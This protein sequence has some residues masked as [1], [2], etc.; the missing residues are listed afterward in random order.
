MSSARGPNRAAEGAGA[1]R[2]KAC[3]PD[4]RIL[5]RSGVRGVAFVE[6]VVAGTTFGSGGGSGFRGGVRQR[7]RGLSH[8]RLRRCPGVA[9]GSSSGCERR[10]CVLVGARTAFGDGRG[11]DVACA[12]DR[13]PLRAAVRGGGPNVRA[14]ALLRVAER[15]VGSVGRQRGFNPMATA[16]RRGRGVARRMKRALPSFGRAL[17]ELWPSRLEWA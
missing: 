3:W 6:R 5:L 1:D 12:E 16:S 14:L 17:A 2:C 13:R 7:C 8:L 9:R 15:G 4:A 10:G 11:A